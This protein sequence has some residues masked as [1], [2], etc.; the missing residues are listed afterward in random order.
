MSQEITLF[1]IIVSAIIIALGIIFD[2]NTRETKKCL[3]GEKHDW[4]FDYTSKGRT[5]DLGFGIR[6]YWE[7]DYY[8][9]YKCR[10]TK[11]I[12]K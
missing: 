2:G 7:I 6:G 5:G 1:V 11:E 10:K 9:C 3:K 8:R 4:R 12:E